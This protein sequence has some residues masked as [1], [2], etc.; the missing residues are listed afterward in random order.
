MTL[1]LRGKSKFIE[2]RIHGENAWT[3]AIKD[4]KTK[5]GTL[6]LLPDDA[7]NIDLKDF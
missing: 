4:W 3:E 6:C 5:E 7:G 1:F 2:T